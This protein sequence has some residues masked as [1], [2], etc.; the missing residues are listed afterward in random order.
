[1]FMAIDPD[2]LRQKGAIRKKAEKDRVIFYEGD[3][4]HFYYQIV[5]GRVRMV[6][7]S[8]T[9]KEFI[10]GLFGPGDSFGEPAL[11]AVQPYPAAAIADEDTTLLRLPGAPFV[12]LL[13]ENPEIHFSLTCRLAGRLRQ[14]SILSKEMCCS[15]PAALIG[16]V[17]R[18]HAAGCPPSVNGRI[19]V[20]LTRQQIANLTGLRVETVIRT[21]RSMYRKG[22]VVLEKGKV[23][24]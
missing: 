24:V 19:K 23:Y 13:K 2:L 20:I 12:Q 15:E 22:D 4:A 1:M 3:E 14:K 11:L 8:D 6:N 7:T 16:G 17:L 5:S 18:Q 10:Q 9:G 21:I